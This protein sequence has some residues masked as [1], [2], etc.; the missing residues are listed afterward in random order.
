M[1]DGSN[2]P[3]ELWKKTYTYSQADQ[4]RRVEIRTAA[5]ETDTVQLEVQETW[6]G[7]APNSYAQGR[8]KM[9]QAVTGVQTHY[10]LSLIHI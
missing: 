7:S 1:R 2:N 4:V 3:I 5:L 6:L 8:T 9:T 10:E